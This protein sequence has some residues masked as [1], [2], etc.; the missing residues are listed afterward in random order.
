VRLAH[1]AVCVLAHLFPEQGHARPTASHQLCR[2]AIGR[3]WSAL[4]PPERLR[5]GGFAAFDLHA[6]VRTDAGCRHCRSQDGS[7]GDQSHRTVG[8]LCGASIRSRSGPLLCLPEGYVAGPG[9]RWSS[10]RYHRGRAIFAVS[11]PTLAEPRGATRLSFRFLRQRRLQGRQTSRHHRRLRDSAVHACRSVAT[12]STSDFSRKTQTLGGERRE[13]ARM[14][15]LAL[16]R[17]TIASLC[18]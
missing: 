6:A 15:N 18:A 9:E 5:I 14:F 7:I 10:D 8:S 2:H 12:A 17:E 11:A 4:S 16:R 1:Q 13:P 3:H